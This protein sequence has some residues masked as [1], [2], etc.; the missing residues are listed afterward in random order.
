MDSL[1][2]KLSNESLTLQWRVKRADTYNGLLSTAALTRFMLDSAWRLIN[3]GLGDGITSVTTEV[4]VSHENPTPAGVTITI[5]AKVIE[6]K[7]NNIRIEFNAVDETG[8]IAHGYNVRHVIDKTNLAQ[9]A[10][11]RTAALKTI[12]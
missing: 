4:Q 7:S 6:I 3:P 10:E 9:I 2:E 8:V 12:L 1:K 5:E 11:R